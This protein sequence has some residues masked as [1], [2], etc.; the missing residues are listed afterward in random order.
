MSNVGK[1]PPY[2]QPCYGWPPPQVYSF[3]HCRR[4]TVRD[5]QK[6]PRYRNV[7]KVPTWKDSGPSM[8]D[9][10]SRPNPHYYDC[11][12]ES[13]P[14]CAPW[15]LP[16]V[17]NVYQ[18]TPGETVDLSV[19]EKTGFKKVTA[20]MFW[21]GAVGFTETDGC[22]TYDPD[23]G[24]NHQPLNLNPTAVKY[25]RCRITGTSSFTSDD[26]TG[27]SSCGRDVRI[28]RYDG[29]TYLLGCADASTRIGRAGT[30]E[31]GFDGNLQ[32]LLQVRYRCGLWGGDN[33]DSIIAALNDPD[34]PTHL[35]DG[36]TSGLA[37]RD[38]L[39]SNTH[40]G[41]TVEIRNPD[42]NLRRISKM[43]VDLLEP[44]T[45]GDLYADTSRLLS[46]WD[47]GND[48]QMP[49]RNDANVTSS[50][51]VTYWTGGSN[52]TPDQFLACDF[53]DNSVEDGRV[54]GAP[55]VIGYDP[56]FDSKFKIYKQFLP[57]D[58]GPPFL[59]VDSEGDFAPFWARHATQWTDALMATYLPP[60]AFSMYVRAGSAIP[61]VGTLI[62]SKY[63]EAIIPRPSHNFARPCDRHDLSQ[64]QGEPGQCADD[65]MATWPLRWPDAACL[66]RDGTEPPLLRD[67][68]S[69]ACP[70]PADFPQPIPVNRWN[71]TA[72]K[73][74]FVVHV[75]RFNFR[76]VGENQRIRGDPSW[77]EYNP[78]LTPLR[79]NTG[80]MFAI[81]VLKGCA[82]P[83]PCNPYRVVIQ[84][85]ANPG[86]PRVFYLQMP[87][88]AIDDRYGALWQALPK[89]WMQ[90]PL[91]V[92]PPKPC[93]LDGTW[94]EDDGTC[95]EFSLDD[96]GQLIMRYEMR[97][98]EEALADPPA[99]A[100]P[101]P[102]G[103]YLGGGCLTCDQ[104]NAGITTGLNCA[105]PQATI[106]TD[107]PW[108]WYVNMQQCIR[109]GGTWAG[110]YAATAEDREDLP[111]TPLF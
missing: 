40:I 28:G 5:H 92:A 94:A 107:L 61:L 6:I 48:A 93:D 96:N 99:G 106:G 55:T 17:V 98:W 32:A 71:D 109:S 53:V 29:K 12:I 67:P 24:C 13:E 34:Y 33:L 50:P 20:W 30:F 45:A 58:G 110:D 27:S 15:P 104:I 83:S 91:W 37:I 73:G 75:W 68:G 100:P 81:D 111:E 79:P 95:T 86:D 64:V 89:Q 62:M 101:L 41:F 102:P 1:G 65:S 78:G 21:L 103:L 14:F 25:L 11:N 16:P 35:S 90:D 77:C 80:A 97:P 46:Y 19:C 49:W 36:A 56:Y 84:P 59:D 57:G 44:Y 54:L 74:D 22:A 82:T 38:K 72:G 9:P 43:A 18:H 63:A 8:I 70:D 66:C 60:G 51:L 7:T 105:P 76:D 26:E 47:L 108:L 42:Q 88:I 39:I 87:P 52:I 2:R 10:Y 31:D 69:G 3:G 4:H 85:E 23:A